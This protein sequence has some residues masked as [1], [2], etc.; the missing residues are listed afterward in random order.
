MEK[1]YTHSIN[2]QTT[3]ISRLDGDV[4]SLSTQAAAFDKGVQSLAKCVDED[5][6]ALDECVDRCRVE[7]DHVGD[8][9]ILAQGRISVVKPEES[10]CKLPEETPLSGPVPP[11]PLSIP[12]NLS[13][14]NSTIPE[15]HED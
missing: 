6:V 9:L 5:L 10:V 14:H 2:N 4:T 8:E 12:I 15:T 1:K 7:C 3:L 11:D 13:Y